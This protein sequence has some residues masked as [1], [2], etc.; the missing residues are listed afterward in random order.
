M[1]TRTQ[2]HEFEAWLGDDHGLTE[3]QVHELMKISD[4]IYAHYCTPDTDVDDPEMAERDLA[5]ASED[6]R[7]AALIAAYRVIREGADVVDELG[8]A[9]RRARGNEE[10]A[11]AGLRQAA[12]MLVGDKET[13]AGFARRAGVDRMTV[14]D[15]LGLRAKSPNDSPLTHQ[16]PD[17][18]SL[19]L[20]ST[21]DRFTRSD[22]QKL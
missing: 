18:N 4:Q 8:A 14:R 16:K 3:E 15:W 13:Q 6:E 7:E 1:R 19:E 5:Q 2:Q 11:L 20:S 12:M 21:S 10:K 17:S 22:Q 9:L